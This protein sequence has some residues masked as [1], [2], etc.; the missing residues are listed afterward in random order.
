MEDIV[1]KFEHL[2]KV[3]SNLE[4]LRMES[5]GGEIPFFIAAYDPKQ[6]LEV[7]DAIKRLMNKLGTSGVPVLEINLYDLVCEILEKV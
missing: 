3:I 2:Y 7:K 1:K 6:E 4:F 5:L